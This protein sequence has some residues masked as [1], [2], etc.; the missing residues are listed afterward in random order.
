MNILYLSCATRKYQVIFDSEDE[1]CFRVMFPGKEDV[2]NMLT[3]GLYY[4][5]NLDRAIVLINTVS[6]N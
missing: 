3:N 6:E 5:G 2:L 1:N 4:H